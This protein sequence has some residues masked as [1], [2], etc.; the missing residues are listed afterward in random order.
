[1]W[2]DLDPEETAVESPIDSM[3]GLLSLQDDYEINST[4]IAMTQIALT[5][6]AGP[7]NPGGGGPPGGGGGGRGGPPNSPV[8]QQQPLP[9]GQPLQGGGSFKGAPPSYFNGDRTQYKQWWVELKLYLGINRDYPTIWCPAEK[10]LTALSYIWGEQLMDWID[11]QLDTIDQQATQWGPE[12]P[13]IWDELVIQ[14]N[15]AF[16]N[17]HEKDNALSKLLDLCMEP[18]HLDEYNT[19]FNLLA[20]LAGWERDG[21]GTMRLWQQGLVKPLLDAILSQWSRPDTLEEW[22]E[23]ANEEQGQWLEKWHEMD[24]HQPRKMDKAQ[25]LKALNNKK[26]QYLQ[27]DD[28]MNVDLASVEDPE[29]AKLWAEGWCFI[30]HEKGHRAHCCPKR[31]PREKQNPGENVSEIC[32]VK[33]LDEAKEDIRGDICKGMKQLSKEERYDLLAKLVDED[34]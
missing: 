22:Q 9:G 32:E 33:V 16:T 28:R 30:C 8:V 25:L 20:K 23:L 26:H 15:R 3:M 12:D 2:S 27:N 10:A 5:V 11:T 31:Q 4:A 14:M 7:S 21:Q 34:F 6:G 1:M 18:N 13:R 24:R 17:T 19:K 29:K